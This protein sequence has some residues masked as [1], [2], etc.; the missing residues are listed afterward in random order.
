VTTIGVLVLGGLYMAIAKPYEHGHAPAG[1][2]HD[3]GSGKPQPVAEVI[4]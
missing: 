4:G 1:D 3:L 2:A